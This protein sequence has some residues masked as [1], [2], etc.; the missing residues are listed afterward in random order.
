ML[1]IVDD[2]LG[3]EMLA[4]PDVSGQVEM[5]RNE[6]WVVVGGFRIDAIAARR[7]DADHYIAA[8]DKCQLE[9]AISEGRVG[10]RF[11]PA[12]D[13]LRTECFGHRAEESLIV[14]KCQ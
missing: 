4:Q 10:L 13:H 3:T 6:C 2:G 7:L 14:R 8:L 5:R 12:G 1:A 9:S 11:A